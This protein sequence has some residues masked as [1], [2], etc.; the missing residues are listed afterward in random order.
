MKARQINALDKA[1]M[2]S[3][4]EEA[5]NTITHVIGAILSIAGLVLLII[6][7]MDVSV[8]NLI[9]VSIFGATLVS[10]YCASSLYHAAKN[11]V[12]KRFFRQFDHINIYILIAGTYTPIALVGL[13]PPFSW[14]V[15]TILWSASVLGIFYK[16]VAF[17]DNWVSTALYVIMGWVALGFIAQ[18]IQALPTGCLAFIV[19]G[20]IL[21]TSGVVFYMLDET[22][23]YCHFIWHL[24]V[25]LG[26]IMHFFA[27]YFYI[28]AMQ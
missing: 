21:Y 23:E 22:I 24:F 18:L 27:I 28:A 14:I 1:D 8:I 17:G 6:R 4:K 12:L 3:H 25:L 26:S 11:P 10:M 2:Y 13:Q 9:A 15:L 16:L 19:L 5:L 20:G 7:A